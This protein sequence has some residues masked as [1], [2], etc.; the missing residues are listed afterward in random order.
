MKMLSRIFWVAIFVWLLW[1]TQS[2]TGPTV[3]EQIPSFK[4]TTLTGQQ[5]DQNALKG[6]VTVLEFWATWC[7]ACIS[8]LPT[9]PEINP[10]D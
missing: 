9:F 7:P 2:T 5:I 6:R 3:D 4:G 8:S 1:R 10:E